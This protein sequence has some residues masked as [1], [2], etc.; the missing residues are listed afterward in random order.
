MF[1]NTLFTIF[2]LIVS[3]FVYF[4]EAEIPP[5]PSALQKTTCKSYDYEVAEPIPANVTITPST[6]PTASATAAP[7]AGNHGTKIMAFGGSFALMLCSISY[8]V[9]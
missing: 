3:G 1:R 9:L 4:A 2:L 6:R 8:F 5:A 7:D